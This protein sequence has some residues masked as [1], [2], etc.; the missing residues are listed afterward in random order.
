MAMELLNIVL[1]L[2][3]AALAQTDT[4]IVG[5]YPCEKPQPWQAAI[6]NEHQLYCGGV[7]INKEWVMT[8][9]HCV[10]RGTTSIRVGE[11]NLRQ[12]DESEQ[13][14]MAAKS[15]AHPN[16]NPA[17]KDNDIML[18][19]LSSPVQLN[20]NVHPIALASS[21][22]PAGIVCLVSGWGTTTTPKP[23][24]FPALLQCAN[25]EI[26]SDSDCRRTYPGLI[27]DNM[28]CAGVPQGGT[29]SC[30]GD[31]GGPLVCG[32]SLQG[33]VSWGLEECAQPNKPGVYSKVSKYL[34]WIQQTIR[35]G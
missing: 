33:I 26:I 10:L 5:G 1:L 30:Q 19:K 34:D 22:A 4:R 27:T 11:Y 16:Y 35:A 13:V 18:I 29:D 12:M 32:R 20:N 17:T 15:V 24:S 6:F 31:S 23:A 28:L 3:P 9:A 7:L 14:K 21:A 2:V 8:A 25:L